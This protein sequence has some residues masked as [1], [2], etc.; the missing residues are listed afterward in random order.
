MSLLLLFCENLHCHYVGGGE[1]A[2]DGKVGIILRE[3][4]MEG[5]IL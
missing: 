3:L 1:E 5:V 2:I 4:S